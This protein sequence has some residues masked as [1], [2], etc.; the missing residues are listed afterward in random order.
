MS[1]RGLVSGVSLLSAFVLV[2]ASLVGAKNGEEGG[3]RPKAITLNPDATEYVRLLGGP[4]E[5]V[6]MHSGLVVLGEGESVGTH[7]TKNYEEVLVVLEGAGKMLITGGPELALQRNTLAY[8]PPRTEHN[9][10]NIGKGPLRY[11]YI[12]ANAE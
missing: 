10:T 1:S 6:T 11:V 2:L 7:N 5:T 4:P 3:P 12:V 8:C 9:V